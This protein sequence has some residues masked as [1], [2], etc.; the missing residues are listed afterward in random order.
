MGQ[1]RYVVVGGGLAGDAAVRGIRERDPLGAVGLIGAELHAPYDRPPLSKGLWRGLP[2]SSVFRPGDRRGVELLL[3]RRVIALDAAE[4]V[5]TDDR[6]E[7]H[8]YERLLLATGGVP[9]RIVG[10]APEVVYLRGLD[11]YR[12]LR[13]LVGEASRAVVV[14]G[15]FIGSELAAAFVQ[16]RLNVAMVL[17][18]EGLVARVLPRE[19]SQAVT[20][21]YRWRGVRVETGRRVVRVD[22]RGRDL[23]ATTDDGLEL[24]AD[25]VVAGLGIVPETRLAEQSGLAVD[26]GI[27]VND[28]LET[29]ARGVYAAG[30]AARFP[31]ALLGGTRRIE[32][33]DA[34]FSMGLTA[35][36]NMAGAD[37]PF[38]HVPISYADLFDFAYEAVGDVDAGLETWA[39]WREPQ[40][41]GAVFYGRQGRV[42][43]VLACGLPGR[44][45][46]ARHLLARAEPL[47]PE[48]LRG[49]LTG[50]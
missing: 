16:K 27:L 35:G 5:V 32:H 44:I 50:N 37:E 7:R 1:F 4:R 45:E 6:G 39:D 19:L 41:V 34:A 8:G 28:R 21:D 30:D 46:A 22:R 17:P 18:E 12:R 10:A 25:V 14:G 26:D 43:G 2:E 47:R 9:R 24:P 13:R 38:T 42:V 31:S 3:G 33:E 15:G 29:S 48:T 40:K 20:R 49:R 11:D 23:V 36:R